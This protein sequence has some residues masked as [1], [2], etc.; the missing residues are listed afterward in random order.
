MF[1]MVIILEPTPFLEGAKNS[2]L[3]VESLY[4]MEL[5]DSDAVPT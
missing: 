5:I 1:A 2:L 3:K 4:E